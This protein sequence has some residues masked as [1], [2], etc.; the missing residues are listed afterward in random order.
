MQPSHPT[1]P[2]PPDGGA[3]AQAAPP[4]TGGGWDAVPPGVPHPPFPQQPPIGQGAAIHGSAGQ[5]TAAWPAPGPPIAGAQI[6][7]G[8]PVAPAAP[9]APAWVPEQPMRVRRE[10]RAA[11]IT[12]MAAGLLGVVGSFAPWMHVTSSGESISI[13]GLDYGG[14][15]TI[16]PAFAVMAVGGLLYQRTILGLSI[17]ALACGCGMTAV[18]LLSFY[19]ANW[20]ARASSTFGGGDLGSFGAGASW[21]LWLTFVA[22]L[23]IIV[24]GGAAVLRGIWLVPAGSPAA[25]PQPAAAGPAR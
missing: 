20:L 1:E 22:S 6:P 7:S 23:A 24:A 17:T 8:Y 25:M 12:L 11:A 3:G 4:S 15:L 21:G 16:V 2:L 5:A 14:L 9:Q 19:P 18:C 13:H 10:V